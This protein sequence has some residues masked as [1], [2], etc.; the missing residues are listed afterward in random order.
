[1][2]NLKFI[3]VFILLLYG[4]EIIAQEETTSNISHTEQQVAQVQ[5]VILR[6]LKILQ[7]HQQRRSQNLKINI[8]LEK[9]Y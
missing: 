6:L 8:I 7:R 1:M 5:Q 2:S 3:L 9:E 4:C